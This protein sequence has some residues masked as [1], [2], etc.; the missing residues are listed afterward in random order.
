MSGLMTGLVVVALLGSATVGGVF[1]AFSSF[2]M[3][4]L[5]QLPPAQGIAAMQSINIVVINRSFL[6]AF[7]GT[8]ALSL[9]M[10]IIAFRD[11]ETVPAGF[12]MAAAL[13]YLLGTFVVTAVGNVPLNN[14]LAEVRQASAEAEAL[15][16]NYLSRWTKLNTLRTIAAIA[17]AMMYALAL[18]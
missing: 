6:G 17:A 3:K 18:R 2:V 1:Y 10:A 14:Q 15:W 5:R 12:L 7:M 16:E 4:A 13:L 11:W 8:A 9:A